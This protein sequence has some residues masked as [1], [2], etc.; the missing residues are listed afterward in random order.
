[1]ALQ[2]KSQPVQ[3]PTAINRKASND[4]L[5]SH[6]PYWGCNGGKEEGDA[7][8]LKLIMVVVVCVM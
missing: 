4:F 5:V 2:V 7:G 3:L 6:R 8:L 1:M